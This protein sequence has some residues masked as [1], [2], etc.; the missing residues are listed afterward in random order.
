MAEAKAKVGTSPRWAAQ[1]RRNLMPHW[2][3]ARPKYFL[4]AMPD[5]FYL[6]RDGATAET[7]A[8][9]DFEIDA[10]DL[11]RPYFE[12]AKVSPTSIN[13]YVFEL[14]VAGWLHALLASDDLPAE[15]RSRDPGLAELFDAVKGG[16]IASEVGA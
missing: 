2:G 6:W 11:L 8:P 10:R 14:I 1:L 5:K 12:G 16:Y 13:P 7:E 4:L 15:M 3:A 9:A